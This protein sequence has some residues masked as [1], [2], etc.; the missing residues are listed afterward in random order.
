[1]QYVLIRHKVGDY[2]KWKVMFDEHGATRKASGSKG[3]RL[4]RNADDPNEVVVLF[5]WDDIE[6]ARAFVQSEDLGQTMKRAGVLDKPDI[7]YLDEVEKV[8]V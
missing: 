2:A 7:Y 5:E 4:F 8:S 6:K 1:M 3:G